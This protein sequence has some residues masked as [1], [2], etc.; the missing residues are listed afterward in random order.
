MKVVF[1][2]TYPNGKI[3]VGQDVTDDATFFGNPDRALIERDFTRAQRHK[4]TITKKIL[5]KS[6][7]ATHTEVSAVK[8]ECV[9]RLR[10]NNP[11]IGYNKIPKFKG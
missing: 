2:I 3:Y 10:S 6:R 11:K 1:K 4:F 7:K 8:R 5:W 9:T